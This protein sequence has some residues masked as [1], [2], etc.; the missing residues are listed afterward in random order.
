MEIV[1]SDGEI[2]EEDM[3]WW[4]SAAASNKKHQELILAK[5]KIA[6]DANRTKVMQEAL[7]LTDKLNMAH[8]SLPRGPSGRYY[9][10]QPVEEILKGLEPK[11]QAIF[12]QELAKMSGR[13]SGPAFPPAAPSQLPPNL[14]GP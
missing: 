3:G 5:E 11:K 4:D 10:G 8:G 12:L 1:N 6:T 2:V 9:D 14:G 13:S 7:A